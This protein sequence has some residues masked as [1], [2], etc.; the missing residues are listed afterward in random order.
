MQVVNGFVVD[1]DVHVPTHKALQVKMDVGMY[2][3][4]VLKARPPRAFPVDNM[5]KW[6]ETE[7]EDAALEAMLSSEGQWVEARER[8][9]IDRLWQAWCQAAEAYLTRRCLGALQAESQGMHCG[10]GEDR[11]PV[12][13]WVSAKQFPNLCGAQG[14][15]QRRLQRLARQ[16]EELGRK[17]QRLQ[18]NGFGTAPTEVKNLWAN[19][20]STGQLTL[21]SET[22]QRTWRKPAH[23]PL[24]EVVGL[25]ARVQAEVQ[26]ENQVA[27][28]ERSQR[29]RAWLAEEGAK[30]SQGKSRIINSIVSQPKSVTAMVRTPEGSLTGSQAAIDTMLHKAWDPIFCAYENGGEPPWLNFKS[31]FQSYMPQCHMEVGRL[32]GQRLKASLGKMRSEQAAGMEGWRVKELKQLPGPL[33]DRLAVFLEAVENGG[34]WPTALE[35]ALVTFIA[36]PESNQMKVE[37]LRPISVMSAV[38]RLWAATRSQEVL[39]WQE[40]W[41]DPGARPGHGT[42]TSLSRSTTLCCW[43]CPSMGVL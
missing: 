39:A 13:R 15:K 21:T 18:G 5:K 22:W 29:W 14:F 28:G 23:P 27:R 6:S 35:R 33:L 11:P 31:R 8:Q 25:T 19:I 17:L 10:R 38:Y 2:A 41:P 12:T 42:E 36:K 9:D 7:E 24:G 34:K 4:S 37:D 43:M 40:Q 26:R 20:C 16:C 30:G 32:T 1:E 3:K